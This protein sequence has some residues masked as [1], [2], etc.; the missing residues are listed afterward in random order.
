M[1]FAIQ[2]SALLI[3]LPL[4]VL[5]VAALVRGG[6]RRFP[7]IFVYALF[8]FLTTVMLVPPA[9]DYARGFRRTT[10]TL[11]ALYWPIEILM[12]ILVILVVMSLIYQATEKSASRRIIRGTMIAAI[13]AVAGAS[14]LLVYNSDLSVGVWLTPWLRNMNFTAAV[15][16]L[17]LWALLI[18]QRQRD[19]QVLMLSGG[20]GIQFTGES[21]GASVQQFALQS[22]SHAISVT[23]S[24]ISTVASVV[25]LYFW[26][27]ALRQVN[28]D[29]LPRASAHSS[30]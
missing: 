8:D 1:K 11:P 12:Q 18:A 25:F 19:N 16:D 3:G 17:G 20:L 26:W 4:Q 30:T 14:F 29:D 6:Y 21:I 13:F 2:V 10:N 5:I 7:W 24:A 22:R 15:L 28:E 9:V 23:G 27:Q